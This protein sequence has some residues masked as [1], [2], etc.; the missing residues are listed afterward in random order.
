MADDSWTSPDERARLKRLAEKGD[1]KARRKL[2]ELEVEDHRI[3]GV[4]RAAQEASA[5]ALEAERARKREPVG[6]GRTLRREG[7]RIQ[8]RVFPPGIGMRLVCQPVLHPRLR[9]RRRNGTRCLARI[10]LTR[11]VLTPSEAL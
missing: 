2:E 1:E 10:V 11:S 9:L 7:I 6:A 3:R 4:R 8:F 5:R